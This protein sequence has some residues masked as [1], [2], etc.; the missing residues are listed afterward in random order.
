[1]KKTIIIA[2]ALAA[3]TACNKNLIEMAPAEEFGF[4]SLGVTAD[5][6]M[7]VTKGETDPYAGYNVTLK[8]GDDIKWS[9]EYSAIEDADLKQPA[10]TYTLYVENLTEAEAAPAEMKGEVRVAG[11]A[12]VTVQAGVSTPVTV[13][14]YAIN[15]RVTVANTF[16]EGVFTSAVAT[17]T[18]GERSFAMEWGHD[19]EKGAYYAAGESISWTLKVTLANGTQKTYSKQSA[20]TT[21]AKKWTQIN[22]TNS[23]TDGTITVSIVVDGTITE[24]VKVSETIDPLE[25]TVVTSAN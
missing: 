17:V 15:S 9:K 22:F 20:T 11:T 23:N 5:T 13:N 7:V 24:T 25:G 2:A 1:M 14:C 12:D 3:M 16:T 18:D 6:E 19:V 8:Q 21:V 10:G 4:I